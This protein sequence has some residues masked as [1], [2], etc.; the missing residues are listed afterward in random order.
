VFYYNP[1]TL[2][3]YVV[4]HVRRNKLFQQAFCYEKSCLVGFELNQVNISD[5]HHFN[6]SIRDLN[7]WYLTK[8]KLNYVFDYEKVNAFRPPLEGIKLHNPGTSDTIF[9]EIMK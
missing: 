5:N 3:S 8:Y 4:S 1:N 9:L 2:E 6:V 7:N